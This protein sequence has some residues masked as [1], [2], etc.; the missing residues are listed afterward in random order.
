VQVS[1]LR[2]VSLETLEMGADAAILEHREEL[3][4]FVCK[5]LYT[6][7]WGIVRHPS[8]KFQD[9]RKYAWGTISPRDNPVDTWLVS[10]QKMPP[11][12]YR[13][14][15][16]DLTALGVWVSHT[17]GAA[18]VL[19]RHSVFWLEKRKKIVFEPLGTEAT[20]NLYLAY[21]RNSRHK[22]LLQSMLKI[23]SFD[24]ENEQLTV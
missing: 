2:R 17:K 7:S 9:L 11:P 12:S 20:K 8:V 24:F 13:F 18:T 23:S 6:E 19:P 22:A 14:Y 10:R 5:P 1:P 21:H 3:G 16:S 15:W 4:D